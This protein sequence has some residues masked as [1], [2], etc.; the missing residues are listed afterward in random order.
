MSGGGGHITYMYGNILGGM[1][2]TC[3]VRG[4]IG[5]CMVDAGAVGASAVDE[6][7]WC[8]WMAVL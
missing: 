8:R 1:V 5:V 7:D 4:V 6:G 3:V 2:G